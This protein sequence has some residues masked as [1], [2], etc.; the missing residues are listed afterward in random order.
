MMRKNLIYGFVLMQLV[1]PFVS[2]AQCR[3]THISGTQKYGSIDV[4]VT[5]KGS[6]DTFDYLNYCEKKL[7][8]YWAGVHYNPLPFT[9][10][11]GSYTF[12]FSP[13]ATELY[14][15]FGGVNSE[16]GGNSEIIRLYMN[17]S[18]YPLTSVGDTL[19]CQQLAILTSN[20]DIASPT[21][22]IAGW[23]GTKIMGTINT[24]TIEDSIISG[25][26]NG[27]VFSV[28][29]CNEPLAISQYAN[30]LKNQLE[31]WPNPSSGKFQI[32]YKNAKAQKV[33]YN[34]IGQ[35]VL[36]TNENEMDVSMLPKGMYYL[37]CEGNT[38]K[39]IIE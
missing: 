31:V 1:I 7:G 25:C 3:I 16:Q 37:K 4:T 39:V 33:L 28:F 26:A 34:S 23:E 36:S 29:L 18:H 14:L 9:C 2:Q 21:W 24:L 8:P 6:V 11:N 22:D 20:G 32:Q 35:I 15:N 17:G 27:I 12:T 5:S 30:V 19:P 10:N 38:S 13:P